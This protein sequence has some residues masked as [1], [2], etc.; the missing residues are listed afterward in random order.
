[1]NNDTL[2]EHFP[3]SVRVGGTTKHG[4]AYV[5]SD[6]MLWCGC[7]RERRYSGAGCSGPCIARSTSL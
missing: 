2:K 3:I 4:D 1:M 6:L 5:L 7:R